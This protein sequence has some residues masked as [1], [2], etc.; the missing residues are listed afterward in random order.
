MFEIIRKRLFFNLIPGVEDFLHAIAGSHGE[1]QN[2]TTTNGSGSATTTD[3][4]T[5][6]GSA[7]AIATRSGLAK[8]KQW[9]CYKS[10]CYDYLN[11]SFFHI[12]DFLSLFLSLLLTKG[13]I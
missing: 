9:C 8:H 1:Q 3:G 7:V 2:D 13:L 4:V 11:D 12:D 6:N 10:A 5:T